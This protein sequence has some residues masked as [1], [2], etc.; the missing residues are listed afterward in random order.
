MT[1][2][3]S[4]DISAI[5]PWG[6]YVYSSVPII[7]RNGTSSMT[8]T[9]TGS[10]GT[11][12]SRLISTNGYLANWTSVATGSATFD[13]PAQAYYLYNLRTD[14]V[15]DSEIQTTSTGIV[16]FTH[17]SWST[18]VFDLHAEASM[19]TSS[20]GTSI[21]EDYAYAYV[22][23]TDY[24]GISYVFVSNAS[25]A[26]FSGASV[27]GTPDNTNAYASYG[28]SLQATVGTHV[29]YQNWT[30][31]VINVAPTISPV[32]DDDSYIGLGYS[33][34]PVFEVGATWYLSTNYSG[35]YVFDTGTG[36]LTLDFTYSGSYW[37]NITIDDNTGAPNAT[38]YLLWTVDVYPFAEGEGFNLMFFLIYICMMFALFGIGLI[39]YFR[40]PL[41]TVVAICG[42]LV[43]A[44]P[45]MMACGPLWLIGIV[46]ILANISVAGITARYHG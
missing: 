19:F 38:A 8:V 28:M 4:Y 35:I 17:T 16:S 46:V 45:F 1:G 27:T 3:S 21:I 9:P 20:P 10:A 22:A 7:I 26:S 36:H 34:S 18:H 32:P 6:G 25:W 11:K 2:E 15:A 37:F 23:L 41:C 24:S 13:V 14:Y 12:V 39:G 33:Y 29:E 5:A 43:L 42:T 44:I 40:I 30:V 31:T